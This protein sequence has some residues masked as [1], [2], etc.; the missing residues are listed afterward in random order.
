MLKRRHV[1]GYFFDDGQNRACLFNWELI[2]E[3]KNPD[4]SVRV[5]TNRHIPSYVKEGLWKVMDVFAGDSW[6][7]AFGRVALA[8]TGGASL[9][10]PMIIMTFAVSRTARLIVVSV[11]V[12]IFAVGMAA[13][14]TSRENILGA[15]AAYAAV[16]VVYVGNALPSSG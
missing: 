12:V 6:N 11:A 5:A 3:A 14:T 13:A 9:L 4:L 2:H 15:T 10:V 1:R 8:V 7:D 16:M